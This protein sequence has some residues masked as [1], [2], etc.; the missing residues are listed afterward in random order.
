MT[1]VAEADRSKAVPAGQFMS[2]GQLDPALCVAAGLAALAP[3]LADGMRASSLTC[4]LSAAS[5]P[6]EE[7][8]HLVPVVE[9][10]TRTVAFTCVEGQAADGQIV[11]TVRALYSLQRKPEA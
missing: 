10:A 2:G 3:L 5:I 9:K 4:D 6:A 1:P 8:I 7:P 11:F